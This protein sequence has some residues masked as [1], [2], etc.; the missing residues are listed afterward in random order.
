ME[1]KAKDSNLHAVCFKCGQVGHLSSS[2]GRPK[3]CFICHSSEHL[4]DLCP[5]W[6]HQLKLLS[7]LV[8]L[9]RALVITTL[10]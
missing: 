3:V 7:T 1:G 2:C 6:K 5:A 8:V 10:M 4:V 9:T